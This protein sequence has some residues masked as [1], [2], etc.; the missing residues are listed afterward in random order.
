MTP[1]QQWIVHL[2]TWL[3]IGAGVLFCLTLVA[4]IIIWRRF[5]KRRRESLRDFEQRRIRRQ[6]WNKP[7][8]P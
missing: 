5:Q 1:F 6:N 2:V 7:W 3:L 8:Q 4:Q